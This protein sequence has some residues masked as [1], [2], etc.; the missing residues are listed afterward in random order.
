MRGVE[1]HGI[2]CSDMFRGLPVLL[3]AMHSSERTDVSCR[4]GVRP[5]GL[6][7]SPEDSHKPDSGREKPMAHWICGEELSSTLSFYFLIG[8][9]S[10]LRFRLRRCGLLQQTY[11]AVIQLLYRRGNVSKAEKTSLQR[12]NQRD[13]KPVLEEMP[14]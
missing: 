7:L 11:A 13:L 14:K 6:Y 12:T 8:F 10:L 1:R 2:F 5:T 3:G 4:T 9:Y